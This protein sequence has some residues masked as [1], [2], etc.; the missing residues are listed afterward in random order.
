V[1]VAAL[2]GGGLS[3][4]RQINAIARMHASTTFTRVVDV[5]KLALRGSAAAD[6]GYHHSDSSSSVAAS[7]PMSRDIDQMAIRRSGGR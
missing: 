7:S 5:Y 1:A 2:R 6:C 4:R 3:Q